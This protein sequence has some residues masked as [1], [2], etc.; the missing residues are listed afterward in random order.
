MPRN[1]LPLLPKP[2]NNNGM[3][4][5]RIFF[6]I[7]LLLFALPFW[8]F[9]DMVVI[10]SPFDFPVTFALTLWFVIFLLIPAKLI[11][12]AIKPLY[13]VIGAVVFASLSWWSTPL[14]HM[15]SKESHFGHCGRLTYTGIF[16]PIRGILTDAHFDDLE[17]RNQMCWARKLISK[18]PAKFDNSIEVQTYTKIIQER[19]LSPEVKFRSTLPLVAILYVRINTSGGDYV[20][21][22][23]IY[24]SLHLWINHYTEE[25]SMRSYR[26]WNWPHS[27]YIK[28][29]YGLIEKNWQSLIDNIIVEKI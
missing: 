14:S 21:V 4:R 23:E 2:W 27:D 17:A 26:P 13:L 29:E 11:R 15:S 9:A 25:I 7:I 16:Y 28:W 20:G 19:L 22:K 10:T 12:P 5:L 24:D 18:V 6:A 8:R 1:I 3:T